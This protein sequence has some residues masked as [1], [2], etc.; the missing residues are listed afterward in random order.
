MIER[1]TAEWCFKP[2]HCE[3]E[4]PT[5]VRQSVYCL[6]SGVGHRPGWRYNR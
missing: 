5:S 1:E 3:T 2:R 4:R 6:G